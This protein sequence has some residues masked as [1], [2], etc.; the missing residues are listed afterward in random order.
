MATETWASEELHRLA[1]EVGGLDVLRDLDDL[2][3][4]IEPF[5]WSGIAAS[6]RPVVG[7][8]LDALEDGVLDAAHQ[9]F[10]GRFGF[11]RPATPQVD[12]EYRTIARRLLAMVGR[13]EPTRLRRSSAHRNASALLWLAM[14]GNDGFGKRFR[15]NDVWHMFGVSSCANR[16]WELRSATGLPDLESGL[17]RPTRHRVPSLPSPELLHSRSRARYIESRDR[18]IAY[19]L[20]S[21]AERELARP[22]RHVGNGQVQISA[23]PITPRWAWRVITDTGRAVLT[24]TL[25]D[26]EE[27][28]EVVGLSIPDARRLVSMIATA[29][30]APF[31]QQ[32]VRRR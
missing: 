17:H 26:S 11:P 29:L 30:D 12:E 16:G 22:I 25:G 24:L 21:E 14:R 5:A 3:L 6:D 28:V 15:A 10:C 4:P 13:N 20:K 27:D 31:P 9:D 7:A 32:V 19:A 2:P 18:F 1:R 23:R 8:V